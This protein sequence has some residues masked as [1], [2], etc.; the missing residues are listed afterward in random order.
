MTSGDNHV[1]KIMVAQLEHHDGLSVRHTFARQGNSI[2]EDI[3]CLVKRVKLNKK[4][5]YVTN[6]PVYTR[7]EDNIGVVLLNETVKR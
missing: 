1:Q 2:V 7:T 4:V 5:V 3:Q 6:N